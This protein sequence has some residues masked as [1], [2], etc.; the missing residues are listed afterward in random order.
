MLCLI[1]NDRLR[2]ILEYS[3]EGR[4]MLYWAVVFLLVAVVAALLGFA[5]IATAAAGI[6][7]ILFY[8]FVIFFVHSRYGA[9]PT[10][11]PGLR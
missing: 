4:I 8:V 7:K 3:A 1:D 2:A 10:R 9:W 5:G 6:A 11:H